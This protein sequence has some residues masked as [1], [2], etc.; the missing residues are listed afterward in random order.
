MKKNKKQMLYLLL[1]LFAGF[2]LQAQNAI[3]ASGGNATSNEGSVSFTVGQAFA[4]TAN[5]E[6][7]NLTAGVQ[8]AFDIEVVSGIEEAKGILLSCK[9]YPNPTT[10]YLQL[11]INGAEFS[12]LNYQLFN[13]NGQLIAD[14]PVM[15]K[16]TTINMQDHLPAIYILRVMSKST[17]IKTFRIV[18]N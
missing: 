16:V 18:K 13:S 2:S 3:V 6:N 15:E 17:E 12:D 7:G 1:L 11:D 14:Q 5:A 4:Q 8:Q 9:A 10:D